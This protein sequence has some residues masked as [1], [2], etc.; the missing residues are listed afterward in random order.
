MWTVGVF[1]V[2]LN[3]AVY[4]NIVNTTSET[5]YYKVLC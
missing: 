3:C 4:D 5:V 1:T 2:K